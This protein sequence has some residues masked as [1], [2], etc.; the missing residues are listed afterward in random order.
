MAVGAFCIGTN[1]VNLEE[2][3]R[4]G[5]A[6]FNAPYSNTRSVVELAI[7]EM[8]MLT[9]DITEKSIK[10]HAGIWDKSATNSFEIRGKKL[11]LEVMVIL[12]RRFR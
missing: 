2:C 10:M 4:R 7:G 11:G 3:E 8:I 12:V 5:I 1:Q 9:R 6:V